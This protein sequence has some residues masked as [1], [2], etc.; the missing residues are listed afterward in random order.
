MKTDINTLSKVVQAA[1]YLN[2]H[3]DLISPNAFSKHIA[4]C[5]PSHVSEIIKAI[6]TLANFGEKIGETEIKV[7]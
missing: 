6:H 7:S 2:R 1:N 3:C 5:Q 4:S